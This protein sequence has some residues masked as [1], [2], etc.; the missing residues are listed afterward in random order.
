MGSYVRL[1]MLAAQHRLIG[2][3]VFEKLARTGRRL[4]CGPVMIIYQSDYSSHRLTK[5]GIVV[6][7]KVA[8]KAVD[9]NTIKR[10]LRVVFSN[11]LDKLIIPTTGLQLMILPQNSVINQKTAQLEASIWPC[12]KKALAA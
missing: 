9:R 11:A 10:R 3:R 2:E 4:R 7:T 1:I 6:S 5:I 12:L 8:K